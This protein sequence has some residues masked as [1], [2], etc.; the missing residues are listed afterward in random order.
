MGDKPMARPRIQGKQQAIVDAAVMVF[1]TR[2]FWDTPTALISKTAGIADG[3]LFNYFQTKDDLINGVYLEIKRELVVSLLEGVPENS[4]FEE[5]MR[6]FWNQYIDWG[7]QNPEKFGVLQQIG[8]SY[9]IS[10]L[11]KEEGMQPF[12][13][14]QEMAVQSITDG[15]MRDY[16]VAYLAALLEGQAVTT[17]RFIQRNP[18]GKE[19]YKLIGFDILWDGIKRKKKKVKKKQKAKKG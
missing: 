19:E 12:I 6:H 11:V 15:G 4:N 10:N 9:D 1:A 16:P 13:T 3:T 17:I 8:S 2:G 18:E 7:V 14:L 5:S